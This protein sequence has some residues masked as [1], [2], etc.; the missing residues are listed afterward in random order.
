MKRAWPESSDAP[1]QSVCMCFITSGRHHLSSSRE[2][3][4]FT[5][6]T[7][8]TSQ[9]PAAQRLTVCRSDTTWGEQQPSD[10]C[11]WC[12]DVNKC[13]FKA[14]W[15]CLKRFAGQPFISLYNLTKWYTFSTSRTMKLLQLK[16]EKRSFSPLK[17]VCTLRRTGTD[18]LFV[19]L[20]RPNNRG[21]R[22]TVSQ[23]CSSRS[24]N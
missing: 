14:A 15:V 17:R 18:F 23:L 8:T 5:S 7:W 19:F 4:E 10:V 12:P 6:A 2:D 11:V 1:T 3:G 24:P 16:L 20:I 22:C 13:W 9:I 21:C